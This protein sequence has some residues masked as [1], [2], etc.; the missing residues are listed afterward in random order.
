MAKNKSETDKQQIDRARFLKE[1]KPIKLTVRHGDEEVTVTL[2]VKEFSG[3][4]GSPD[5]TG[6]LGWFSNDKITVEVDG[7]PLRLQPTFNLV[8]IGSKRS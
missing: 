4:S 7:V 5:G 3:K 6:S 1:A 8:V 2:R